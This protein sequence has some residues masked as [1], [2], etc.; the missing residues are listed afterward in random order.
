NRHWVRWEDPFPKPSYLFA[1][2]AGDLACHEDRI[3]TAS[4]REVR[5]R[6]FVEHENLNKTDHAMAS[7]KAAMRWDEATYGLECDLDD[8]MVVA[9]G[10]FNMGA[11]ENKG[12]NIFNT[13]YVLA[14]PETATDSDYENIL[15]VVG[16]E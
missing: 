6:I 9:V 3:V 4:G 11:M 14:R 5:L 8:Y 15:A 13:Q 16:H 12:L 7:L 10:D 1:L 2:V